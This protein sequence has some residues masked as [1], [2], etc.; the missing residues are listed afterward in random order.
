MSD[1]CCLYEGSCR[2]D[3][4]NAYLGRFNLECPKYHNI[5]DYLIEIASDDH[6]SNQLVKMQLIQ[7]QRKHSQLACQ[8]NATPI[9]LPNDKEDEE[10]VDELKAQG[11]SMLLMA[12]SIPTNNGDTTIN[13]GKQSEG[14]KLS[15]TD[16][17][18][19]ESSAAPVSTNLF[20]AIERARG[21]R[22]RPIG[23]QF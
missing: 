13:Y 8:Q 1:G 10:E 21:R 2:F 17:G 5:A 19:C 23:T 9:S 20:H 16:N 14:S 7:Y 11:I 3:L 18:R 12:T 15:S 6:S 4:V 22:C